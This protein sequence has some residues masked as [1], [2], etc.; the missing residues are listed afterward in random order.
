MPIFN[1][2]E[3]PFPRNHPS[4]LGP[5]RSHYSFSFGVSLNRKFLAWWS[6][7]RFGRGADTNNAWDHTQA[8]FFEVGIGSV[9][10]N[11]GVETPQIIHLFIGFSIIF[12]IHFW[13]TPIF[14]NTHLRNGELLYLQLFHPRC[15]LAWLIDIGKFPCSIGKCIFHCHVSVRGI[16]TS[17]GVDMIVFCFAKN[18]L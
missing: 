11:S 15:K 16:V 6:F 4:L 9:S 12:T 10:E 8:A 1:K 13:G 7:G 14:G 3:P 17:L 18:L 2:P 5:S